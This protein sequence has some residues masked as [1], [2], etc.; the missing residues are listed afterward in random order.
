MKYEIMISLHMQDDLFNNLS[1]KEI[2][3]ENKADR[4]KDFSKKI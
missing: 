2:D 1:K 3:N 4:R